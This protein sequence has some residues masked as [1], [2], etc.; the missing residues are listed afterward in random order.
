[1]LDASRI[2]SPNGIFQILLDLPSLLGGLKQMSEGFRLQ[3]E[4]GKQSD[5]S[6]YMRAGWSLPAEQVGGFQPAGTETS[7]TKILAGYGN[8]KNKE[9][10]SALRQR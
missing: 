6:K 7:L 10:Q 9:A 2:F 8:S 4:W 1:M 3:E 5:P